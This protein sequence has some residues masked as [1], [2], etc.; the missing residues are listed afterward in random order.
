[1]KANATHSCEFVSY[2]ADTRFEFCHCGRRRYAEGIADPHAPRFTVDALVGLVDQPGVFRIV[3][4]WLAPRT[5]A[6]MY[7]VVDTV[8]WRYRT[9]PECDL[10]ETAQLPALEGVGHAH[11]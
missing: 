2:P 1:M 8:T 9:V 3:R 4:T 10:C 7:R 11:P 6:R 5:F